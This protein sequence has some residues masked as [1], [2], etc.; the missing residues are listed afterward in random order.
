MRFH[1]TYQLWTILFLAVITTAAHL[2][3]V[4]HLYES[5][6]ITSRIIHLSFN[7][8]IDP[9]VLNFQSFQITKFAHHSSTQIAQYTKIITVGNTSANRLVNKICLSLSISVNGAK[10]HSPRK[11]FPYVQVSHENVFEILTVLSIMRYVLWDISFCSPVKANQHL[12][13]TYC[14]HLGS[15]S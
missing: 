7:Y 5:F 9:L 8:N 14:L 11:G 3:W 13:G 2:I 4:R 10:G 6:Q 15:K 12:I 1:H